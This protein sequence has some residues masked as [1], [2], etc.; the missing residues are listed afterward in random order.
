MRGFTNVLAA[1]TDL[2]SGMMALGFGS[3]HENGAHW[4]FA[5]FECMYD[6]LVYVVKL[7]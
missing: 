1:D 3:K 6:I 7:Y 4:T 2:P 5:P